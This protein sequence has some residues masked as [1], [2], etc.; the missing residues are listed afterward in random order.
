LDALTANSEGPM[1]LPPPFIK[2]SIFRQGF[3]RFFSSTECVVFD[4]VC[5]FTL[6]LGRICSEIIDPPLATTWLL[7]V[8]DKI[9]LAPVRFQGSG[10]DVARRDIQAPPARG[11]ATHLSTNDAAR[12]KPGS[13]SMVYG[14]QIV[15]MR[16]TKY[17]TVTRTF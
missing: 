2:H 11:P 8:S 12:Q 6:P 15:Y 13:F 1:A 10:E 16:T 9:P 17:S 14:V 5:T 7:G 4:Y 3:H